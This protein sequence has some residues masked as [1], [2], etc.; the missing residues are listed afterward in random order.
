MGSSKKSWLMWLIAVA[1]FAFQFVLR[2]FPGLI[3]PDLMDKFRIDATSFGILSAG[4]YL[5]YAGMQIP[6]GILLDRYSPRFVIAGCAF[7][8]AMGTLSFV[9]SDVWQLT[10][11]GRFLIGAGSAGGFLGAAKTVRLYFPEKRFTGM[12][13]LTFTVG[14]LGAL[15]GG[16]PISLL[17]TRFGWTSILKLLALISLAFSVG[18]LLLFSKEQ[19]CFQ[20]KRSSAEQPSLKALVEI[21]KTPKIIWI[22]IAGALMVGPLEGFA[23]IWGVAYLVNVYGFSRSDASLITSCIYFGMLFG[24]PILSLIA[25]KLNAH[26][27]VSALCGLLMGAI[28]TV[29]LLTDANMSKLGLMALMT[30]VGILCCYQVIVFAMACKLAPPHLSGLV[31]SAT[32]CINMS[33]GCLLHFAM[34]WIMDHKWTGALEKGIKVYDIQ[35][36]TSAIAVIP[37]TLVIGFCIFIFIKRY[38]TIRVSELS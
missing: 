25:Q 37:V 13:G 29:L 1:F 4:Y 24:G 6:I 28:F 8:C 15:Y 12:I 3:M 35:S 16:S 7:L 20:S 22:G 38:D 33:A 23:D 30:F 34:G 11:F 26:Y 32:N 14:L 10:I 31:T 21:L 27:M 36:Y 9:Y 2:L 19:A 17:I 18:V 5:G